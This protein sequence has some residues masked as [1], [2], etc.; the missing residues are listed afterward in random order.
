MIN[1]E[2]LD[3][4]DAAM[5]KHRPLSEEGIDE[6]F[7]SGGSHGFARAIEKPMAYPNSYTVWISITGVENTSAKPCSTPYDNTVLLLFVTMEKN[8]RHF[9][10]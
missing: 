3:K 7:D 10:L 1:K 5:D 8:M 2:L 9:I 6:L 4:I